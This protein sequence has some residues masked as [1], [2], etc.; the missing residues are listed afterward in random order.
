MF[1]AA[2]FDAGQKPSWLIPVLVVSIVTFFLAVVFLRIL[3]LEITTDGISYTSPVRGT[4]SL[5]YPEMSSVVLIDYRHEGNGAAS[6]NRS[7]R[8]WTMVITPK[9]E[10]GKD[11]LKIPLTFFPR[12]AYDELIRLLKPEVWESS[13]P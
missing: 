7:L 1:V 6:I 5:T 8:R 3:R 13:A 4:N 10:T 2:L 11:P 12:N 9:A